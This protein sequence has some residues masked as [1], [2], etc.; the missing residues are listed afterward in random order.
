VATLTTT[1]S[2]GTTVHPGNTI[3]YQGSA[4]DLDEGQ[5]P[6]TV[7]SWQILCI[8]TPSASVDGGRARRGICSA[9]HGVGVCGVRLS[10]SDGQQWVERH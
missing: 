4:V 10:H 7:L 5:L 9:D 8:M 1:P 3:T 2:A 6:G